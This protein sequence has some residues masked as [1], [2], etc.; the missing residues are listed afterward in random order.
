MKKYINITLVFLLLSA[1]LSCNKDPNPLP[2]NGRR[3]MALIAD[4][5]P[6]ATKISYAPDGNGLKATWDATEELSVVTLDA[7]G[8]LVAVDKFTSTG[9]DGRTRA[10]FTGT[11]TGGANPERVIVIYPALK[12]DGTGNWATPPYTDYT[13]TKRT[14]L[15]EATIG[16]E[17]FSASDNYP[18]KQTAD[19]D[20]KHLKN[21]CILSGDVDKES[22]KTNTLKVT[23]KNIMLM[24]KVTINYPSEYVGKPIEK[25]TIK[26]YN[27][28]YMPYSQFPN[29]SWEYVDI[30]SYGINALGGTNNDSLE[31]YAGFNVPESLEA[32]FYIPYP[33]IL[34]GQQYGS[35]EITS[36]VDGNTL[37][38]TSM[39]F[40]N[41]KTFV[42]GTSYLIFAPLM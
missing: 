3:L 9:E 24:L 10:E 22:I 11:F 6:D 12:D 34:P 20:T 37:G 35:W 2:D 14:M 29:S 27:S 18:L 41:D 39:S 21:Y 13:G 31:L 26:S 38:P 8:K 36:D 42:R 23:M 7:M 19:A 1:S 33:N 32:T 15:G 40:N 5:G 17:Y 25:V 30:S 28:Y 4:F 16:S